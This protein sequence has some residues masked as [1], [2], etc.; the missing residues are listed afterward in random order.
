MRSKSN[1][2]REESILAISRLAELEESHV[3]LIDSGTAKRCENLNTPFL[4]L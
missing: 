1:S 3:K 4:P 2:V